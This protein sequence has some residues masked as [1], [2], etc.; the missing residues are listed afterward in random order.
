MG[1]G[2]PELRASLFFLLALVA[3]GLLLLG[4]HVDHHVHYSVAVVKPTVRPGT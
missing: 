2:P 4:G 1:Q 3:Q